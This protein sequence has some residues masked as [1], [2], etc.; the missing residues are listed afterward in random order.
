[1]PGRSTTRSIGGSFWR[2]LLAQVHESD[3][4]RLPE[5][6]LDAHSALDDTRFRELQHACRT[7][8]ER[9]LTSLRLARWLCDFLAERV[10]R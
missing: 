7:T 8:W 3:P 6:L 4:A 5:A 10:A 1:V 9:F 2:R